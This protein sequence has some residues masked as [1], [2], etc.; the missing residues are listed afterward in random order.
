VTH[1]N[2]EAASAGALRNDQNSL[3]FGEGFSFSGYERDAA[4][5]NLGGGRFVDI[6]GVSGLDSV[7]DNRAG[8]IADF[9]NDG[10]LDVFSTTIQGQAHLLFRNNVGQDRPWLRVVL[11]GDGTINR[12]AIG[13]VV[14]IKTAGGIWTRLKS[15]GTGFISQ[16]DSRLLFGL[17]DAR[18]VEVIEVT[19]PDGRQER[20]GGQALPNT[21]V[22]LRRGTGRM[23]GAALSSSRLPD[24]LASGAVVASR[25]KV[26]PGTTFPML[27]LQSLS[28]NPA[29]LAAYLSPGRRLLVNIWA[30][31]C[32]PCAKEMPE[33]QRLRA[34]LAAQGIDMLGVNVD[35]E[36]GVDVQGYVTR[37]GVTYPIGIGGT[38]AIEQLYAGE[39]VIVPLSFLIDDTGTLLEIL[40][41]WSEKTGQRLTA[42]AR[43]TR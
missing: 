32:G 25:L 6:S 19:W 5:L 14:R 34:A 26:A 35:S 36:T 4:F 23:L 37:L 1:K 21:T 30:T 41:G 38:T 24:P 29:P 8:V 3:I 31:W 12:E 15:A 33:L 2:D 16:H 7:A 20:F 39:E 43:E 17:G 42:L 18:A 13:S 10:D 27:S 9:D 28:G 22:V 40:P 11:E